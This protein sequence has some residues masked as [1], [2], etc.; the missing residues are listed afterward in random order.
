MI[1]HAAPITPMHVPANSAPASSMANRN[2]RASLAHGAGPGGKLRR[3]DKEAKQAKGPKRLQ[4]E[5][6]ERPQRQDRQEVHD[7]HGL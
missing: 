4:I 5:S 3:R 2:A 1:P 7:A 6:R